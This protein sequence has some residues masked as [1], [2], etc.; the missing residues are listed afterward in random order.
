MFTFP[1]W[2]TPRTPRSRSRRRSRAGAGR[3]DL[4]RRTTTGRAHPGSQPEPGRQ[5]AWL[6]GPD[7]RVADRKRSR[8]DPGAV[9]GQDE[10]VPSPRSGP[11][12]AGAAEEKRGAVQELR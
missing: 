4:T 11:V 3:L 7:A 1:G 6:A 5:L 8:P 2:R 12:G 10:K 9:K